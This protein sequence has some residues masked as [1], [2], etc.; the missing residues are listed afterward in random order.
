MDDST[1]LACDYLLLFLVAVQVLVLGEILAG[2][3]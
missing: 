2:F 3:G 1:P